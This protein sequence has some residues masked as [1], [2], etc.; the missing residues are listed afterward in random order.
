M[1]NARLTPAL[2]VIGWRDLGLGV[3]ISR[4]HVDPPNLGDG[5]L[6]TTA[7]TLTVDLR[8]SHGGQSARRPRRL[9]ARLFAASK[10]IVALMECT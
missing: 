3:P 6:V 9:L 7:L 8:S 4:G 2:R 1:Q 5:V 10:K